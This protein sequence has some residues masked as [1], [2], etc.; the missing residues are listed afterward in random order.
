MSDETSLAPKDD[1]DVEDRQARVADA[2]GRIQAG[3]KQRRAEL[4][5][6]GERSEELRLALAE[7]KKREFVEEPPCFSPRPVLGPLL[8]F[9]RK[10]GFHL[11]FKWYARPVQ[12]Q[13]N[14]FNQVAS[15]RIQSLAFALE[16]LEHRVE[17]LA[18]RLDRIE[19][20][21]GGEE[22]GKVNRQVG[23]DKE[24]AATGDRAVEAGE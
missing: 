21:D 8:V 1:P 18:R 23:G 10:A 16:D 15:G 20:D 17:L 9:L 19:E 12:Q 3:V 22:G 5:T 14:A 13:Q 4:A 7:L 2:L 11:F 6:L 24:H